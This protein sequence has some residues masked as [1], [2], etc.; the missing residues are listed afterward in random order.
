MREPVSEHLAR[1][2]AVSVDWL[3]LYGPP[4]ADAR[5]MGAR[6]ILARETANDKQ[7]T[8]DILAYC[9]YGA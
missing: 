6:E 8:E 2:A 7:D 9:W 5:A 1:T 3:Y 4:A